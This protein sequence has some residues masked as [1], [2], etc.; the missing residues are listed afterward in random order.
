MACLIELVYASGLRVSESDRAAEVGRERTKDPLITVR[1]KGDK[2]R[3]A[4]LSEPA[5]AAMKTYRALLDEAA[6]GRGDGSVACFPPTA[7]A[8]I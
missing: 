3:L 5:R 4:P 6:P 1:G 7:T 2:E 8:A